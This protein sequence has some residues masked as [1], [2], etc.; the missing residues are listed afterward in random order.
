[1]D[2]KEKS[3]KDAKSI[4]DLLGIVH[5]HQRKTE[6]KAA[7]RQWD[8]YREDE[9]Q[10]HIFNN[11]ITPAIEEFYNS[12]KKKLDEIFKGDDTAKVKNKRKE[13]QQ[14]I[15]EG[16]LGYFKKSMPSVLKGVEKLEDVEEKYETL[17]NLYDTTVLGLQPGE[18]APEGVQ[19]L[20]GFAEAVTKGKKTTVGHLKRSFTEQ[21]ALHA[22]QILSNLEEKA[23]EHYVGHIEQPHLALYLLPKCLGRL[24]YILNRKNQKIYK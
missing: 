19:R 22:R 8:A 14:S 15:I 5:G 11:I 12:L 4:D 9:N 24:F 2:E 3:V 7:L 6:I 13:I 21:K 17:T 23:A 20:S 16:L 10:N 18:Q 1:M